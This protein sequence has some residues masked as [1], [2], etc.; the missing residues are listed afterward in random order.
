MVQPFIGAVADIFPAVS[1]AVDFS[2]GY[3]Y[4]HSTNRHVHNY[5][6]KIEGIDGIFDAWSKWPG[7]PREVN[8]HSLFSSVAVN[9]FY[10]F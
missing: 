8:S 2:V 4:A 10:N 9:L 1:I 5:P 3:R 7:S 6:A